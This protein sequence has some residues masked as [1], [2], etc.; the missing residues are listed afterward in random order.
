MW[1]LAFDID[2]TLTG[3]RASL[4]RLAQWIRRQRIARQLRLVLV[5]GRPFDEVR[6]GWRAEG[7]PQADAVVCQIGT[8]IYIPPFRRKTLPDRAWHHK[9]AENF[10]V[11]EA[12]S[13]LENIPGVT[14]QKKRYNTPFKVSAHLHPDQNPEKAYREISRRARKGK[15]RYRVIWSHG[16]DLDILPRKAGKGNALHYLLPKIS[17]VPRRVIVAG[18]SGNDLDLYQAGYK[19]IVVRNARPE[20]LTHLKKRKHAGIFFAKKSFAAGLAEGLAHFI[21]KKAEPRNTN[22]I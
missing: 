16:L 8:D 15:G 10:S 21:G 12:R 19:A 22:S 14:L 7:I 3:N 2:G 5:T 13:F 17:S 18:N 20:L 9:I 1:I 4:L 11:Q 6:R